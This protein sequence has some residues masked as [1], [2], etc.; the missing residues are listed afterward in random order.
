M[1]I[2]LLENSSGQPNDNDCGLY[3]IKAVEL[4]L[5]Q[6]LFVSNNLSNVQNKFTE[7]INRIEFISYETHIENERQRLLDII[8]E[9]KESDD[10]KHSTL[11]NTTLF[12]QEMN[13]SRNQ[14][15]QQ[16]IGHKAAEFADIMSMTPEQEQELD[17]FAE[18]AEKEYNEKK[19]ILL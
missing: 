10:K 15:P 18:Q 4:I 13:S 14:T 12:S 2:L 1:P 8:T 9:L 16:H 19:Y 3:I 11:E 6:K 7:T 5:E 17:L